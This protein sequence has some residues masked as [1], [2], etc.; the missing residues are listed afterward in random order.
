[1][2]KPGRRRAGQ[3]RVFEPANASMLWWS[4]E[5][6]IVFFSSWLPSILKSY[7]APQVSISCQGNG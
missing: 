6:G 5:V 4:Q 1:M 3:P 2:K 7:D